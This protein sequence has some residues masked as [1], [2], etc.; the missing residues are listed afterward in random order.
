M[1]GR[2]T[3][4]TANIQRE[5]VRL[6]KKGATIADTCNYVGIHVDTYFEW[7]KR[8]E[9]DESPFSEFSEA[10]TRA[11]AA[12]HIKAVEA[13]KTALDP[14]TTNSTTT[15]TYTETR[16]SPFGKEFEYKEVKKRENITVA[17]PDWRAA[18]EYLKRRDPK[19]WSESV[20]LE[21]S[22]PALL[23][24]LLDLLKANGLDD[25]QVFRDMIEELGAARQQIVSAEGD[26]AANSAEE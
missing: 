8:G 24:E 21:L 15:E 4:L 14:L 18:V 3:K 22:N 2:N 1:A 5:V 23:K 20:K 17:P 10:V 13:I 19:H 26:R 25:A 6:L 9:A 11:Q 12:A 7:L 16:I